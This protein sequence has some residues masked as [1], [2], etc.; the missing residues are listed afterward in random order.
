M[1]ALMEQQNFLRDLSQLIGG[2]R[3]AQFIPPADVL[4]DQ[5]GVTVYMDVPGLRADAI[6]V[7]LEND[8]LSIRGERPFPYEDR[9][10]AV[11]RLIERGFGRFERSLRVPPGLAPD[12][13]QAALSDGVLQLRIP[14]PQSLKP[15]RIPIQVTED[16]P[17]Q[18]SA[19]APQQSA[20]DAPQQSAAD[21]PQT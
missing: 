20:A 16:G 3:V 9:G 5:E 7:E 10:D 21:A 14:R 19:D 17:Q 6:E 1:S 8:I 18:L 2:Q 13:V 4:V 12:S 11:I 15:H